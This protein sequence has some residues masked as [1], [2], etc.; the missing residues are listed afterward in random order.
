MVTGML[1]GTCGVAVPPGSQTCPSCGAVASPP[2]GPQ[3]SYPGDPPGGY[4]PGPAGY[5]GYPPAPPG[6]YPGYPPSG[7]MPA[8]NYDLDG[9]ANALAV[10]LSISAVISLIGALFGVILIFTFLLLLPTT[11]VFLIWFYRARQNAGHLD[12]R[13]RWS[14]GWSIFGWF[15]PICFLWFPYQIMLDIWRA[16]LQAPQRAKFPFLLAAWWACWCLAWFTGYRRGTLTSYG[17]SGSP[18]TSF[19]TTHNYSLDFGGTQLSLAFAAIA[20]VLLALIVKRVS[21][22]LVGRVGKL[23]GAV[24]WQPGAPAGGPG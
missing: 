6:G 4:P 16:G 2:A 18:A 21:G 12:S 1:C 11:V 19:T 3:G 20:A 13:Q 14:P 5:P 7:P 15:V 10:M 9:L 8:R 23:S 24:P 17:T 22:G